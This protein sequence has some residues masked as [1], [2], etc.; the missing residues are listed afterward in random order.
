M[1]YFL[2]IGAREKLE[3]SSRSKLPRV[4]RR[5]CRVRSLLF[6]CLQYPRPHPYS[7]THHG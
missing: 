3:A 2:L 1:M 6:D 5:V 4:R 7:T